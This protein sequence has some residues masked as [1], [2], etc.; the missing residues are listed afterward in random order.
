M[1]VYTKN[2]VKF[3]PLHCSITLH[4]VNYINLYNVHLATLCGRWKHQSGRW[5]EI[6]EGDR[7]KDRVIGNDDTH[8]GGNNSL[9]KYSCGKLQVQVHQGLCLLLLSSEL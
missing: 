4:H 8:D 2:I 3:I 6:N 5:L 9:S 1:W 7:W